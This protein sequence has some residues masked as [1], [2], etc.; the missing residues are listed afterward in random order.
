MKAGTGG[1]AG[2]ATT[3]LPGYTPHHHGSRHSVTPDEVTVGELARSIERFDRAM[4]HVDE[5]LREAERDRRQLAIATAERLR[6]IEDVRADTEKLAE[7]QTWTMRAT[8]TIGFGV[9][10]SIILPLI[11]SR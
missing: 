5:R 1:T 6:M 10:C 3:Y 11:T 9:I 8:I 2:D 7:N 4:G